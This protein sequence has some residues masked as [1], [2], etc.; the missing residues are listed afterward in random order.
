MASKSS[1][2]M[3]F[4]CTWCRND[5]MSCIFQFIQLLAIQMV[6]LVCF[7]LLIEEE[8]TLNVQM[9]IITCFGVQQPMIIQLMADGETVCQ[10]V[11]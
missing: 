11:G 2:E 10:T 8:L 6:H 7:H 5:D 9:L 3:P 1:Q 4:S